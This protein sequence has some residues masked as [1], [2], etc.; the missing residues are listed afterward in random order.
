MQRAAGQTARFGL[1]MARDDPQ[2]NRRRIS[3]Y[4]SGM[5]GERA[6]TTRMRLAGKICCNC[7]ASLP[8]PHVPG[9]HFCARCAASRT[10]RRRVYMSFMHREG[11]HCQFLEED[12]KTSLPR[13]VT[14]DTP[15]KL[16]E[17]AKRGGSNLNLET[18]Q[19]LDHGIEIGRG[20]VWLELTEEQYAKL[21][22]R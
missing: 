14:L 22:K 15:A 5:G 2:E 21:R 3:V 11:W 1:R 19:A 13:K 9:E 4:N 18:R 10:A 6:S 8:P 12:L 16:I 17:M 7:K 20:G